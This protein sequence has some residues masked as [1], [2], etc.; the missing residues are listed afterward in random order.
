VSRPAIIRFDKNF[1]KRGKPFEPGN[2]LGRGR[3]KGSRNQIAL[4]RE[5]LINQYSP[6]VVR[7]C[8]SDALK[9]DRIAMRLCMERM[10][11][12]A[13]QPTNA[14]KLPPIRSAAD[15]PRASA[16][17]IK[18]AAAGDLTPQEA[19]SFLR[20]LQTHVQLQESIALALRVQTLEGRV[21]DGAGAD[22]VA[23]AQPT[24]ATS[25]SDV[26]ERN[27]AQ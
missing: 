18:A 19:E 14:F 13:R 8:V 9:G 12:P 26:E 2:K 5:A 23:G 21:V 22:L 4:E 10:V 7:K 20:M 27:D 11:P 6:P 16:A 15:V 24:A 25:M 3:P 1:V 17:V